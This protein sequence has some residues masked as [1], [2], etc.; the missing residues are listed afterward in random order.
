MI[1]YMI[2]IVMCAQSVTIYEMF[3]IEMC[4]TLILTFGLGQGQR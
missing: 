1:S 2:T 4:M 3:A